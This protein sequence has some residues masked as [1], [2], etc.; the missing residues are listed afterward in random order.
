MDN[1]QIKNSDMEKEAK[2]QTEVYKEYRKEEEYWRLKSRSIWLKAGDRNTTYF[3]KQANMRRS[4]N[5]IKQLQGTNGIIRGQEQLKEAARAHFK[6][7][8]TEEEEEEPSLAEML[9]KDI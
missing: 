3:H 4:Q 6:N 8:F 1:V 5:H 9:L 2:L 7:L